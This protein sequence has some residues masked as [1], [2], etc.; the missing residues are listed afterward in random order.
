MNH[1]ENRKPPLLPAV[2]FV[3]LLIILRFGLTYQK[4]GGFSGLSVLLVILLLC[5]LLS[6]LSTGA[7]FAA[8]VYQ[9]CRKRGDD[10]VLWAAVVFIATPFIGLLLYFLRRPELKRG[11]PACGHQ[12]SFHANYCEQCGAPAP[13]KE[14]QTM[15][16]KQ[17]THHLP[18]LIAGVISMTLMLVCLTGFLISAATGNGINTDAASDE[19]IWNPGVISMNSSSC[20]DGVW[21]LDFKSA[22]R[23]FIKERDMT[24]E[25]ADTQTLYAAVSCGTVPDGAS[26]TLWLVQNDVAKSVDVTSLSGP[27]EYPLHE[28]ENGS[29]RVR[30]QINGVEDTV[31]EIYIQ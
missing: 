4:S 5:F 30:L 17:K 26:L 18:F 29:I 24:I 10:P 8:W 9:D 15:M 3:L 7:F 11:C 19:K 16:L 14:E 27:L 28:F 1:T 12:I 6:A 23:G 21:K 2:P 13:K 22:S 20:R 25:N 31:S